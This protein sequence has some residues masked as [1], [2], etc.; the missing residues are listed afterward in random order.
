MPKLRNAR[1]KALLKK[2]GRHS[3]GDGLYFR[4]IGLDRAY[5]AY[6]YRAHGKTREMSL[7]TWPEVSLAEARKKH[8]KLRAAVLDKLDPLASR[9]AARETSAAKGAV[10]TFGQAAAAYVQAHEVSWRNPK[11]AAQWRMTLTKYCASIR[12]M[13][14][15]RID[16]R[17]VLRV[18]EPQWTRAP[19]TASRL[20]ARIEAVLSAARTQ[21][22]IDP[23][24]PNP[25][26]WRGWLDQMLPDPRKIGERG[27][28][29]AMPYADLPA[30]MA[31]LSEAE[32]AATNVLAFIVLTGARAGETINA[33]WD[34]IDFDT[35]TW[36]IPAARMKMG[37]PH[38]VPLSDAAIDILKRQD[39]ARG[40]SPYVF[41]GLRPRRPVSP[42]A[43]T[44]A[45]RRLGGGDFTVHGFRSAMRTWMGDNGVEFELAE[46]CLAHAVGNGVVQAYQR[47]SLLER[48][49]PVMQRWADFVGGK[50]ESGAAVV[51]IG[52][53]RNRP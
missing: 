26:R 16:A 18:L 36:A 22:H 11:H 31:S 52:S 14:V 53:R 34:E 47:S 17:A 3:D 8:A 9:R 40:A 24:R 29:A 7:G 10:P 51:S 50:T 13:A 46:Q 20:R 43:L 5:W 2:P 37:K 19:E 27:H 35:K 45:M 41:P 38:A 1:L 48:R 33:T 28:H 4:T 15:D 6:R 39:A 21:G 32:G 25:A 12:D 42:T 30:F 44:V 23:D 49:R